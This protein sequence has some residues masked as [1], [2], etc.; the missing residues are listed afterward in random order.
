[1]LAIE[2]GSHCEQVGHIIDF[3][4]TFLDMASTD[5]PDKHPALAKKSLPSTARPF[6]R[7]FGAISASLT[8]GL[9]QRSAPI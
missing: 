6:S 8:I 2:A 3:L 9:G 5:Y 7:F 4:P 1:M